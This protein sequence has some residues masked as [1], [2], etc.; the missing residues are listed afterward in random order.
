MVV[1]HCRLLGPMMVEVL[2]VTSEMLVT[3]A[4]LLAVMRHRCAGAGV[5]AGAGAGACA[6]ERRR[7][8]VVVP[9]HR[10]VEVVHGAMVLVVVVVSTGDVA[11]SV[12]AHGRQE[13]DQED[14]GH[15][16]GF[17]GGGAM[18]VLSTGSNKDSLKRI[19][20]KRLNVG[21]LMKFK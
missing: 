6:F 9:G 14:E 15:V 19:R 18:R 13:E 7:Q 21:E 5:G 16:E 2:R 11:Q 4:V 17:F 3:V 12:F 1:H 8:C 10:A 20:E